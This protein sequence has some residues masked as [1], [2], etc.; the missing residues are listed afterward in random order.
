MESTESRPVP[1]SKAASLLPHKVIPPEWRAAGQPPDLS[2]AVG[3]ILASAFRRISFKVQ[4]RPRSLVRLARTAGLAP[5]CLYK[6]M[7]RLIL[8]PLDLRP[9]QLGGGFVLRAPNGKPSPFSGDLTLKTRRTS[10]S[11]GLVLMGRA[12]SDTTLQF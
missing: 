4:A 3:L 6:Y 7:V 1:S 8:F 10:R 12:S 11:T 5:R 2:S 9:Q